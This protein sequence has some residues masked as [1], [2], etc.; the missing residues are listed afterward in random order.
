MNEFRILIFIF[1]A[2]EGIQKRFLHWFFMTIDVPT[3]SALTICVIR[4]GHLA[5]WY[6]LFV[7]LYY[8]CSILILI[9][10]YFY[11]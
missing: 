9:G 4:L 1:T 7:L 5:I 10:C 2:D 8:L 3:I 11:E 6:F